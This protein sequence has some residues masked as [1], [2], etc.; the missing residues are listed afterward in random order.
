MGPRAQGSFDV[1]SATIDQFAADVR[2]Y[3]S[4]TPP[5]L[6][7]RYLYD[8]IGSALFE[9]ICLLPWYTITRAE[10]RLLAA[11]GADIFR[12]LPSLGTIVELGPGSGE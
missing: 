8:D 6:P 11:H 7:S 2:Y 12:R 9:T 3:L 10:M 4:L 5:Q 1:E